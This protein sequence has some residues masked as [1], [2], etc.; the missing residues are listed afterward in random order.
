MLSNP[1]FEAFLRAFPTFFGGKAHTSLSS[2]DVHQLFA[3]SAFTQKRLKWIL[4]PLPFQ[5]NSI[6]LIP[7]WL[8]L[9]FLYKT[10]M[11]SVLY[12]PRYIYPLFVTLRID[13]ISKVFLIETPLV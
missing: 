9:M 1:T 3:L 8:G 10:N 5:S 11:G 2:R 4:P 6:G 7:G 12:E 13:G